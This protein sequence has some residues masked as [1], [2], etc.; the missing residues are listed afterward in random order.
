VGWLIRT[1]WWSVVL[2]AICIVLAKGWISNVITV[3]W[4]AVM[5]WHMTFAF[6]A[7]RVIRGIANFFRDR[8]I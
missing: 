6:I 4:I 7:Y 5:L 3:L 1:F 8:P 2:L